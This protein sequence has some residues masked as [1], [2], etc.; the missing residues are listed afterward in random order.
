V[1]T[2]SLLAAHVGLFCLAGI[3]HPIAIPHMAMVAA[4]TTVFLT[5]TGLYFSALCRRTTVAIALN[6]AVALAIWLAL[7]ILLSLVGNTGGQPESLRTVENICLGANPFIQATKIAEG[8]AG[9]GNAVKPLHSIN[10]RWP[11]RWWGAGKS[12]V[13]LLTAGM[14]YTA[15]AVLLA[16]RT[17]RRFRRRIF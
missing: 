13:R 14:A 17:T 12:T 3:I 4:A 1:P 6:T 11:D 7:P 8:A 16:W 5:G 10:Y 15:I 2:W 9:C